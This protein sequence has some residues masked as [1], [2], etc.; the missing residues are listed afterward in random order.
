[1]GSSIDSPEVE[2]RA[3]DAPRSPHV[4]IPAS[5]LL[6]ARACGPA[7]PV[8]ILRSDPAEQFEPLVQVRGGLVGQDERVAVV[9]QD[10]FIR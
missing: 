3:G 5:R 6:D 8:F 10:G 7:P 1:M 9:A 4:A 2:T